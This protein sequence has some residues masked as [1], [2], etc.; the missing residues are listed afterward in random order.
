MHNTMSSFLA[1]LGW[2]CAAHP[3]RVIAFWTVILAA[4]LGLAAAIGGQ[5]R[6]DYNAPGTSESIGYDFLA[7]SFPDMAGADARVV[8]RT[9]S[10][11]L[12]A[13]DLG[14]LRDHLQTVSGV[15][16]VS[17]PRMSEAGDTALIAVQ[18]RVP[19]TEFRGSPGVDA[20]RRA[21]EP[22]QR[23]GLQVEL[24]GEVPENFTA[25]GGTAEKGGVIAAGC[26]L[27][28]AFGSITAAGIPAA[29]GLFGV[30]TGWALMLVMAGF[31][32]K[33]L[34][35]A[36]YFAT[37]LGIGVG[38]D[39]ALLF[40]AR[41]RE[42]L[43]LCP[44]PRDAAGAANGSAGKSILVAGTTVLVSLLGLRLAGIPQFSTF[45]YATA[46]L[47]VAVMLTA[48][49]LVPALCGMAGHRL[50]RWGAGDRP[51]PNRA[52]AT[53]WVQ[54]VSKRPALWTMAALIV[55]LLLAAPALG[56][57][58]WPRDA[59]SLYTS[60]TVR[61]AYDL[62][63]ADFGA[64]ANGPFTVAV[65][66]TKV[67]PPQLN[68]TV[69][70]LREDAGVAHVSEPVFNAD[71]SAAV[72][73]IEPTAAP[74]EKAAAETL[75]QVRAQLPHGTYVT[76]LTPYFADVSDHLARQLWLMIIVVVGLAVPLLTIAF[77][78]PVVAIKA[79]LLNLLSVTATYGV[80]VV[81]F[82]WGWGAALFGLPG[83][84]PISSWAAIL[85]FIILFGLSTDYEVFIVS[86][87]REEWLDTGEARKS[88]MRGFVSTAHVVTI[89]ATIMIA[90]F[91]AFA[92]DPDIVVKMMCVGMVVGLFIDVI[93]I[94]MILVPA[95][96]ALLG[97]FN[98]WVPG[99]CEFHTTTSA[100]PH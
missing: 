46:V 10:G 43:P 7:K 39:Y 53:R 3:W 24:G 86:R 80:L 91:L 48:V 33:I 88:V 82:Q 99:W 51:T 59:G 73:T 58:T 21:I 22:I 26:I 93:V 81:L 66:A 2:L 28:F 64:G 76:G 8:V 100:K 15:S 71:R 67:S 17:P 90:V 41:F 96:M 44:S 61:R 47:I 78:A 45:G 84:V 97:R 63:A 68:G 18:Y 6:D 50:V 77:K 62:I 57:R 40:V 36:P 98:W 37:I 54:H 87:V 75:R 56:M 11:R 49:T 20:L 42:Y 74:H 30:G 89:A 9:R 19:A 79:A 52:R 69:N 85:L 38:I 92:L 31:N 16:T 23:S 12:N 70:E 72:F 32:A 4:T 34:T 5:P 1:R 14:A 60:E 35:A 55:L 27:L 13:A 95:T 25:P 65:D 83:G 29:V 94:R